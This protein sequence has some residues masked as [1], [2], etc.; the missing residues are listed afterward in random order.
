VFR[1]PARPSSATFSLSAIK[2]A[3]G[4]R[5][6][7]S[8]SF[9]SLFLSLLG[10]GGE[11]GEEEVEERASFFFL[12]SA[13]RSLHFLHFPF[14]FSSSFLSASIA[15][16]ERRYEG[17]FPVPSP[18]AA[19]APCSPGRSPAV[20]AGDQRANA[21]QQAIRGSRRRR[22]S[23]SS[24]QEQRRRPPKSS[25]RRPSLTLSSSSFHHSITNKPT[26]QHR[27]PLHGVPEEAGHRR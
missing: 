10:R 21:G 2:A 1:F 6:R 26:A 8:S 27:V 9:L 24:R 12:R 3:H 17:S 7:T 25:D 23:S 5:P 16:R 20:A 13:S 22:R 19:I 14:F 11:R 18:P 15:A 4:K